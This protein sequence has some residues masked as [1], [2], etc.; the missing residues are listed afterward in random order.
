MLFLFCHRGYRLVKPDLPV[1]PE[2]RAKPEQD[3]F[4]IPML[5]PELT[6]VGLHRKCLDSG[7][8]QRHLHFFRRKK[9]IKIFIE[10]ILTHKKYFF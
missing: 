1:E 4:R 5:S 6:L 7:P 9:N 3:L 8:M 10:T 2:K